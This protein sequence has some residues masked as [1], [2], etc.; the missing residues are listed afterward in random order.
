[1]QNHVN[2]ATNQD[3]LEV[4]SDFSSKMD[5]KLKKVDGRFE[6]IDE[7]FDK[8]DERFEKIDERFDKI[9]AKMVTKEYL[10]EKLGDLS[11]KL[12]SLM[13]HEDNKLKTVTNILNKK[14]ILTDEDVKYISSLKPFAQLNKN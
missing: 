4:I 13:R 6:K 8:I 10:D 11:G 12:I 1:M 14:D 5:E 9:E 3:I 7:R 2:N